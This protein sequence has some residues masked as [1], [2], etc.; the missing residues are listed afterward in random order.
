MNVRPSAGSHC[1]LF[2]CPWTQLK[3][4]I[5]YRLTAAKAQNT[6]SRTVRADAGLR[7]ALQEMLNVTQDSQTA[8]VGTSTSLN[9]SGL[10]FEVRGQVFCEGG[11]VK[12]CRSCTDSGFSYWC[13]SCSCW[14]PL[15]GVWQHRNSWW[16]FYF[17]GFSVARCNMQLNHFQAFCQFA[18]SE[19]W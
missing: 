9:F 6:D 5:C 1:A 4:L 7:S 13:A 18:L 14:Q 8:A 15:T 3:Q 12:L 11:P 19:F 10:D 17:A 16:W 2:Q